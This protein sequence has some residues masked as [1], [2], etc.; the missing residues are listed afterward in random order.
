MKI[1]Y[2]I[3]FILAFWTA[4]LLAVLLELGSLQNKITLLTASM[5]KNA[6]LLESGNKMSE[7][8]MKRIK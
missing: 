1:N 2:L 6:V 3:F 4:T 8:V 5:E 7:D